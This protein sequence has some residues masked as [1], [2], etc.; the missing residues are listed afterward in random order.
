MFQPA[1]EILEGAKDMIQHGV[2]KNPKVDAALMIHV[3][4]QMPFPVGTAIVCDRGISAPA[5]D[6]FQIHIQ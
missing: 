3:M 6:Y 4:A 1:E 5:A 2:L